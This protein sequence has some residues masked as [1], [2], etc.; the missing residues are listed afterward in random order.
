MIA[1]YDISKLTTQ[2]SGLN[3]ALIGTGATDGDLQNLLRVETG[4]L[5]ADIAKS[6]GPKTKAAADARVLKDVKGVFFP[7]FPEVNLFGGAQRGSSADF[8]WLFASKKGPG[9]LLGADSED[10]MPGLDAGSMAEIYAR[11]NHKRGAAWRDMGEQSHV[12]MDAKGKLRQHYKSARTGQ[13]AIKMNRIVVKKSPFDALVK[14][15]QN[16][17]GELRAA[18]YAVARHYA[19]KV[20]V[21]SWLKS[22]LETVL[23]KGKASHHDTLTP[24]NPQ[25]FIESTFKAPGLVSNPKIHSVIQGAMDHRAKIVFKKLKNIISG[26]KYNFETGQT[27]KAK[28]L[29]MAEALG[30]SE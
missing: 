14:T 2:I 3:G 27:F 19:P 23:A 8:Q 24:D 29:T 12:T 10:V 17:S 25:A 6:L 26:Y 13:H 28:P 20:V 15:I 5:H 16:K 21:P 22:K 4:Q 11:A 30:D 9:W 18:F 7:I 1:E